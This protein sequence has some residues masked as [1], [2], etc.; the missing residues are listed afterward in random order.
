LKW[1]VKVTNLTQGTLKLD[2]YAIIGSYSETGI[3]TQFQV[4]N[5]GKPTPIPLSLRIN[6]FIQKEMSVEVPGGVPDGCCFYG[7][8]YVTKSKNPFAPLGQG[9]F[10][11]SKGGSSLTGS[12]L[13]PAEAARIPGLVGR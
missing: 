10:S 1:K 13:T 12:V 3:Y 5:K 11:A 2:L 6:K 9:W 8:V 7:S 4:G